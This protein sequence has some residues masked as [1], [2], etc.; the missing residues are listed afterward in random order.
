MS[1]AVEVDDLALENVQII[2]LDKT[3]SL[4]AKVWIEREVGK[5]WLIYA[6]FDEPE[7]AKDWLLDARLRGKA[8]NADTASRSLNRFMIVFSPVAIHPVEVLGISATRRA[9][10]RQSAG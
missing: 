6:P 10:T 1:E 7:P 2:R 8:F 4:Q 5:R 9:T 3:P